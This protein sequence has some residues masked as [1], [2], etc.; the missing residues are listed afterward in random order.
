MWVSNFANERQL[1]GLLNGSGGRRRARDAAN[2]SRDSGPHIIA[3]GI[4]AAGEFFLCAGRS[5]AVARMDGGTR[6]RKPR[7]LFEPGMVG[8]GVVVGLERCFHVT[9]PFDAVGSVNTS[10]Y[11]GT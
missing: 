11:K 4:M 3:A 5:A 7:P 8:C 10:T 2:A 6:K 1:K 9:H